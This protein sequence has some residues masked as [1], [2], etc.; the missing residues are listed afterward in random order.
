VDLRGKVSDFYDER[1]VMS[2][3]LKPFERR[4]KMLVLHLFHSERF[5]KNRKIAVKRD[6]L[7]AEAHKLDTQSLIFKGKAK[8]ARKKA[9]DYDWQHLNALNDY[10]EAEKYLRGVLQKRF[11][12]IIF[13]L[14]SGGRSAKRS[15]VKRA[16]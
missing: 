8:E 3:K 4:I 9:E 15:P 16:G 2:D 6:A 13:R 14:T 11:D 7:F 1:L 5:T 10:N 12:P